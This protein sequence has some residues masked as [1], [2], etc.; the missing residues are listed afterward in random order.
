MR[1]VGLQEDFYSDRNGS[2]QR[3]GHDQIRFLI[4]EPKSRG[5]RDHFQHLTSTSRPEQSLRVG[6]AT[7]P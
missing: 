7:V 5:G 3:H 4:H 6:A 1:V 2:I